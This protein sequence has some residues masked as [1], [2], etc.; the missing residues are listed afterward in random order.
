MSMTL[1]EKRMKRANLVY[2][3]RQ[4]DALAKKEKRALTSDEETRY[5]AIM[6][7]ASNLGQEIQTEEN[8]EAR[9]AQRQQWLEQEERELDQPDGQAHR[10]DVDEGDNAPEIRSTSLSARYR[11]AMREARALRNFALRDSAEYRDGFTGFLRGFQVP[12]MERRDG[13]IAGSDPAGGYLRPPA[14]FVAQMLMAVDDI[15]LFRQPGWAT[16]IPVLNADSLGQVSL[17]A[18]PDDGEWTTEIADITYDTSMRFGKR[19]LKPHPLKKA[20]KVSRKLLRLRPD[21]ETLVIDRFHYKFG[22]TAE[23]A[24]MTGNGSNKPLGVFTASTD[25]ISTGRDV[26]TDNTTSAMTADG[27]IN[28]KFTLKPQYWPNA[29]W[30]FHRDGVKQLAKLKNATTGEYIWRESVRAGEPDRLLNLPLAMSEYAPNTFT[31]GQYVGILGDFSFYEIADSLEMDFQRL[32]ELYAKSGQIGF[33]A[34]LETDGMPVLE[35]AFVRVK[36]A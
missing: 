18:D 11:T 16:V 10:P 22:V 29:R 28:A 25:G 1:R 5:D 9:S 17:D 26:S 23:K 30:M 7:E 4:I 33:H 31:T 15:V 35:E 2:E 24:Y 34:E 36:L 21:V 14:Q 13:L 19:E 20:I 3:A 8:R 27:L 32:V 12:Q 6:D